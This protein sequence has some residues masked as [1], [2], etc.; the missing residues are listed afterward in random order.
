MI[1]TGAALVTAGQLDAGILPLLTLLAMAAFLPVSEIAHIGRQLADTLGAARR[2][3]AVENEP[4]AVVD[5]PGVPRTNATGGAQ[6]ELEDVSYTYDGRTIPAL[7]DI[8][9]TIPAGM[10]VA[11]VGPSGAGKTTLAHLLVRFWDPAKG[12]ILMDGHELTDYGLDDLRQRIA[13]VAQDTYLFN[14]T[15]EQNIRIARPQASD[16]ALA[17]AVA[18]AA[19]NDVIGGL[20]LGLHTP[21][22]ERGMRLSGGQRQRVAIARAFLKD[23]PVLILDEATSH[24]DAANERAVRAALDELMHERTTVVIAHRL[25]TVRDADLIVVMHDGRIVEQG[26]HEELI[27]RGGLYARLVSRQMAGTNVAAGI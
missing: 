9:L 21:V 1:V 4:I 27:P 10:T 11:L 14:Q 12:R 6:L 20:P 7:A 17:E 23:A 5:G 26:R 19:L 16:Q 2:L 13:L 3:Y 15:L 22:G 25:S 8:C 24:L 18:R